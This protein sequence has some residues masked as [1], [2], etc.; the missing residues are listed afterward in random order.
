MKRKKL[1]YPHL[2]ICIRVPSVDGIYPRP[3]RT[4][5]ALSRWLRVVGVVV[6]VLAI[7]TAGYAAFYRRVG[8][9]AVLVPKTCLGGWHNA[10]NASGA[11]DLSDATPSQFNDSNSAYVSDAIADLYCGEFNGDEPADTKPT[12]IEKMSSTGW[13][14]IQNV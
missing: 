6:A 1:I 10:P 13:C 4:R 5:F 12:A 3:R 9:E 11:P 8:A 2:D 7:S 14:F